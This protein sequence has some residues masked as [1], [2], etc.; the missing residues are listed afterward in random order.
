MNERNAGMARERGR[1][2]RVVETLT[3]QSSTELLDRHF[4]RPAGKSK[5]HRTN[6][7]ILPLYRERKCL[8]L[9]GW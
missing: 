3:G 2:D 8:V 9:S 1:W 5:V 7:M 6:P 4:R